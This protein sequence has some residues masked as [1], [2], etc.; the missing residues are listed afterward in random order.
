LHGLSRGVHAIDAR[1]VPLE[2]MG[3]LIRSTE[4]GAVGVPPLHGL[5]RATLCMVENFLSGRAVN[6]A[7]SMGEDQNDLDRAH[8]VDPIINVSLWVPSSAFK[9]LLY[10]TM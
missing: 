3:L 9:P 2:Q 5:V 1:E 8:G 10:C 6:V 4:D 7:R